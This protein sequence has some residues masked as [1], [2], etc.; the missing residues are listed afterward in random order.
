MSTK[1]TTKHS[2]AA[3]LSKAA[4]AGKAAEGS[5]AIKAAGTPVQGKAAEGAKA[6][7]GTKVRKAAVAEKSPVKAAAEEK[8]PKKPQAEKT[9]KRKHSYMPLDFLMRLT[10]T[11]YILTRT[12]KGLIRKHLTVKFDYNFL[13]GKSLPLTQISIK[14]TNLCNL[15]CKMCGQWGEKGYNLAK[16]NTELKEVV[17]LE[18]YKRMVDEVAH[19]K[20]LIYIWG[21]EPFLYPDL[22][23]LVRYMKEKDF[24]ISLVTNGIKLKEYAEEIVKTRWEA[25]MLSLDGTKEIHNEIRGSK[26]CFDTLARGIDA[27]QKEKK[28][29]NSTLPYIMVLVTVSRDNAHILDKILAMGKEIQADCMII[30]YSWFT[31]EEVGKA[32]TKVLRKYLGC[33]PTAWRGYVQDVHKIDLEAL[34]E[35]VAKIKSTRYPF[36]YLFIPD[37]PIDKIDQYYREPGNFFGY[38]KCVTPWLITELMPNGDVSPCRDY[39]DYIVGNIRDNSLL[40]IFNNEKY[41]KFRK[42]LKEAGGVFPIC[43]RCCGLMG[44]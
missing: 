42:A 37:L 8:A 34:K 11:P 25:L 44:F 33:T 17:P 36:P 43:A 29:R 3:R 27:V 32:H 9:S 41:Q 22:I 39:P 23:P 5:K 38:G 15:R 10:R 26:D 7:K 13:D 2:K 35:C 16:P 30:Y 21:G 40:E 6:Q 24:V 18:T 12:L 14:I 20:P 31:S 4:K 28:K 19:L 1:K